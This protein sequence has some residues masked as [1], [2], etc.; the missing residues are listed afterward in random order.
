MYYEVDIQYCVSFFI[1]AYIWKKK[2]K[3]TKLFQCCKNSF[4]VTNQRVNHTTKDTFPCSVLY[5]CTCMVKYVICIVIK[6]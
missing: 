6:F 4:M 3:N 1:V 2:P 5:C